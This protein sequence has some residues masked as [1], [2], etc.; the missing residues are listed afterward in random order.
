MK[1][2][3]GH[4][5]ADRKW[6]KEW[7]IFVE[8]K[9]NI[10]FVNPFYDITRT[11]IEKIDA[12]LEE[13]ESADRDYVDLVSRDLDVMEQCNGMLAFITGC[14][15]YGTIMEIV[16]AYNK[17]TVPVYLIVTNGKENHPWLRYHATEIFTSLKSFEEFLANVESSS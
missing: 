13:P 14:P 7:Q 5:F 2:Y 8:E 4:P 15:S 10:E 3:L 6:I 12:G 1:L 11:D 16:Y 17:G 9:Y